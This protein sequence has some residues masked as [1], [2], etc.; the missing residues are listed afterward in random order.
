MKIKITADRILDLPPEKLAQLDIATMSC[1]INMGD[2][3][4]EDMIDVTPDDVFK[5]VRETGKM[6]QTAAK[7]PDSYEQFFKQFTDKGMAVIHFAA[8][9]GISAIC[10][11][12]IEASKRLQNVYVVDTHSLSGGVALL[13]T[14][15]KSLIEAGQTDVKKLYEISM[16]KRDKLQTSFMIDTLEFLHKGG[17]CSTLQL[18][19]AKLLKLRPVITLEKTTGKMHTREK[20]IGNHKKALA[21]YLEN[22]FKKYPNPDL[23]D[24]YINHISKD[25]ELVKYFIEKA[26]S[27]YKFENI[28]VG[29]I[30]CNC[31]VHGGPNTFGIFYFVK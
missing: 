21:Q 22:T 26:T 2:K 28:H 13:A 29:N 18:Y 12:A 6:A 25:E 8:S 30:S 14:Y 9:S 7:S 23:K 10:S 15:A 27:Y 24:L 19:A 31:A 16:E 1:Y 11:F 17:R 4:Y 3:S 5:F 20:I